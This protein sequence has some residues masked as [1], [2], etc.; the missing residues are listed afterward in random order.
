[1]SVI[2]DVKKEDKRREIQKI[3]LLLTRIAITLH[4]GS[5]E[6]KCLYIASHLRTLAEEPIVVSLR[7]TPERS[8][9][10][11]YRSG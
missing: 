3:D 4:Y 5:V 11:C 2:N 6:S 1:M 7:S 10:R 9:C 8:E